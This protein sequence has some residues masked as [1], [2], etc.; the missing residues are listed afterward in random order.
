M[1]PETGFEGQL[2]LLRRVEDLTG[3]TPFVMDGEDL[4]RCAQP[5]VREYFS[6]IREPMPPDILHW[7]VGSRPEWASRESWHLRAIGSEG[8]EEPAD[9]IDLSQLPGKV[10]RSV[11][12]N[13]PYYE[14]MKGYVEK[15]DA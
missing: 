4:R 9:E 1:E 12:K 7:P 2:K 10:I 13:K 3:K 6:Y 5:I 11:A 14:Q 8:F 15:P